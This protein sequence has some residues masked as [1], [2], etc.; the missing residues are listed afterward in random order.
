M[1]RLLRSLI[2]LVLAVAVDTPSHAADAAAELAALIDQQIDTQLRNE[3]AQPAALADDAEFIRR[4][5]LDLH[6]TVPTLEQTRHFLADAT[7]DKRARLVDALL[8]DESY[9]RY[10]ADMW[11]A[12]LMSP[13][14]DEMA[15]RSDLFRAWL[16]VQFNTRRWDQIVTDLLTA[17]GRM[18][19]N[20]AV[21][22]LIE[23]R[24]PRA[25]PDLTDLTSR[26]FLGVRL[27]CAQCHD[28]PVVKWKQEEFW[29]MAAFFTQIQTPKRAKQV[30][31][32]GVVD[33]PSLTLA[34]LTQAGKPDG[35]MQ[36][37]P[38]F[39]GGKALNAE[40]GQTHR[41]ALAAWMTAPGN[42]F[43]AR[44]M[45]N[46]TWW[47]LFGRGLVQPVDDMHEGNPPSHSV[48]LDGLARRF[49]ASGFDLKF[50]TRAIVLTRA[51]QRT[52][53]GGAGDLAS[54]QT[55]L[56]G[57]MAVKVLSAGQLY[58][59]LETVCGSPG[60]VSGIDTKQGAR[61][62]FVQFFGESGDPDPTAYRR[63]IP[64]LLRQ[65]NSGQFSLSALQSPQSA[66]GSVSMQDSLVSDVFLTFLSRQP[67]ADERRQAVAFLSKGSLRELAWVLMMTSEFSLNH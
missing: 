7:P 65:M 44:A 67:S 35:F 58:D 3:K 64:H 36:L 29:G 31:E 61:W 48:L 45:A 28:H 63:G 8:A 27:N 15:K 37:T 12:Y 62:E 54:K 13:L 30:Y 38:T 21:T 6:G 16:A 33:D 17:T 4:I 46:R 56:F 26:Y 25:V 52:S 2:V 47:R 42:P 22:Y 66:G 53:Q 19:D 5:Y 34:S 1:R 55:A 18:E 60:K 40:A 14:A 32:K 39:P 20:P 59:A 11:Q 49:A 24:L 23:A 57:R 50:L 41:A 51:Y 9:G 10:M 43:F